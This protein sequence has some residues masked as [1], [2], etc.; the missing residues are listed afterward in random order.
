[1]HQSSFQTA[2]IHVGY[3]SA[4]KLGQWQADNQSSTSDTCK[5]R[6]NAI[7]PKYIAVINCIICSSSC[8]VG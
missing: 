7:R 2:V 4:G 5:Q 1:M 8:H 6:K 3:L